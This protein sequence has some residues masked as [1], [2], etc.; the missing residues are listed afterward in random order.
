[1]AVQTVC[2]DKDEYLT[3]PDLG[4]QFSDKELAVIKDTFGTNAKVVL[5]VGDGLSSAAIEANAADIVPAIRQGLKTFG[6]EIG[7][8]LF[9]KFCRV[10]ALETIG[11]LTGA[12]VVCMLIGERPGLVTA[13]SMSCYMTYKPRLDT[14]IAK[15]TV[16]S[17]IHSGGTVAVEAGAH[18][19]ELIKMMLDKKASGVDLIR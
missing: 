13:E 12:D 16:I 6:I 15:R 5:V 3:R 4:R 9:V 8:I 11:E 1:M 2:K 17:N 10:G 7:K 19:A 18:I 14:P